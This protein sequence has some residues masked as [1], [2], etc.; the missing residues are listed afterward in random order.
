MRISYKNKISQNKKTDVIN[1]NNQYNIDTENKQLTKYIKT[2]KKLFLSLIAVIGLSLSAFAQIH[3]APSGTNTVSFDGINTTSCLVFPLI[4]THVY[5]VWF[6]NDGSSFLQS[7]NVTGLV[8]DVYGI[9]QNTTLYPNFTAYLIDTSVPVDEPITFQ[10]R[11]KGKGR[12]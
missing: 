2:M 11:G 1:Y 10:K 4:E 8:N 9:C 6:A 7:A 12:K 3:I 5:E